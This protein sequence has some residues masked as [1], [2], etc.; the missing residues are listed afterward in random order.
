MK[1]GVKKLFLIVANKSVE[2]KTINVKILD[3]NLDFGI[4]TERA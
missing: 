4:E 1:I 3:N 2:R